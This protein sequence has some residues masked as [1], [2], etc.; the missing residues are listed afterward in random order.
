MLLLIIAI[1]P[2]LLHTQETITNKSIIQMKNLG[3]SDEVIVS[4]I[5]SPDY[6]FET[7]IEELSKMKKAGLSPEIISRVM[8]KSVHNSKSKTGIYYA[9]TN[10]EQTSIQPTIFLGISTNAAAQ[11]LVSSFINS[12]EKSTLPKLTSNN[13]INLATPV[14]TFVFDVSSAGTDNM[15]P[16]QGGGDIFNWWFQTASPPPMNSYS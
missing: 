15:Q 10:G 4:K 8:E 12:K 16:Q 3:F 14:F 1:S 9:N 11:V 7:S 5:N 13:V 2:S 6:K